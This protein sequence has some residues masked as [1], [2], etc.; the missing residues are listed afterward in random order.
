MTERQPD[1]AKLIAP[2][3]YNANAFVKGYTK[4]QFRENCAF[5]HG[6]IVTLMKICMYVLTEVDSGSTGSYCVDSW[7]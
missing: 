4:E 3:R 5:V 2:F 1:M 7:L 6:F